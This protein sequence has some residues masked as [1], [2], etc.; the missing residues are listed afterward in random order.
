MVDGQFVRAKIV[1]TIGPASEHPETMEAMA[2]AGMDVARVNLSHGDLG[3]HRR[4]LDAL[5]EIE[6]V[7]MLIDLPGP[8]I[9]I[10]DVD[11][12]VHLRRGDSVH[13]TTRPVLGDE[14]ELSV[15]YGRLPREMAVGGSMFIDDGLIEISVTSIDDDL[16]GFQGTV[17][18]GGEVTRHKGINVPGADLTVRTPTES[19]LKGIQFG[20]DLCDWFAVSF[21]RVGQDVEAARRAIAEAGGDQ[22]V[23]SKIEHR[24]AITNIDEIIWASDGVMIARGDLGI[25]VPPW[26]VPLL[27]KTIIGKCNAAGKPVIVATQMLESMAT[28][29][30]PTRAE[31]SDVANAILDGADAV[32]LSGETAVGL[33]PVEAVR[34]M[35]EISRTVERGAPARGAREHIEGTIPDVIGDLAARATDTVDPAAIIVVTRSGFTA[36]MVSKHRPPT[37]ILTVARSQDV[38]RRTRLYWGVEPLDVPWSDDRDV[39][40]VRAISRSLEEGLIERSD[41]VLIVSGSTLEAPGGTSTLEILSVEDVLS[42]ASK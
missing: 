5:R 2:R 23:V 1:C 3:S 14:K 38:L 10:G 33:F 16:E 25:E 18:S 19:D 9:R 34:V 39:L 31:A 22:P 35:N 11:G 12:G 13:F 21:V 27:Q 24:E 8:K 7:S 37:R 17:V 26:E 15:S 4:V 41:V 6:G 20:I 40:L 36:R 28:S 32:M 42:H 30:R 29:P